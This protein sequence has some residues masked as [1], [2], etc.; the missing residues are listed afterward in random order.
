VVAYAV[1]SRDN[2]AALL[3][4]KDIIPRESAPLKFVAAFKRSSNSNAYYVQIHVYFIDTIRMKSFP[5][6]LLTENNPDDI[7]NL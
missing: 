7:I 5:D 3:P 4:V 1:T 2:D 6:K